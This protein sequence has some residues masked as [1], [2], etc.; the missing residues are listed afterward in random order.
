MSTAKLAGR[1]EL[2]ARERTIFQPSDKIL[3]VIAVF[4]VDSLSV[5]NI[6]PV[7]EPGIGG[8]SV[9]GESQIAAVLYAIQGVT[10]AAGEI[11]DALRADVYGLERSRRQG[12]FN[13]ETVFELAQAN[14]QR[15][16]VCETVFGIVLLDYA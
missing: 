1:N 15:L 6:H 14:G 4:F 9:K 7:G 13:G 10:P 16:V 12:V 2:Q 8:F 3:V 11:Y 5:E